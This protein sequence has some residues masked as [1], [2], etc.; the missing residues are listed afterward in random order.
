MLQGGAGGQGAG[1]KALPAAPSS[2]P[3][4]EPLQLLLLLLLLLLPLPLP[5]QLQLMHVL[6]LGPPGSLLVHLYPAS[7]ASSFSLPFLPGKWGSTP[8]SVSSLRFLQE[9]GLGL[10]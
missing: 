7:L 1:P 3:Q 5:Y 8:P 4:P 6:D 2:L 10:V 9:V